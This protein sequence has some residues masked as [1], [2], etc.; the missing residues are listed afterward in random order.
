MKITELTAKQT[1]AVTCPTCGVPT[2]QRCVLY[3][4]GLRIESHTDRKLIAAE[5][6]EK[7]KRG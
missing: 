7:K 6:V 1:L 5:A 2:G 3:S 4:G